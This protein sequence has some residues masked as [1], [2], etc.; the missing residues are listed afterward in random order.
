MSVIS[1][2]YPARVSRRRVALVLAFALLLGILGSL[3]TQSARAATCPCTIFGSQTPGTLAEADTVPVELGVKFRADQDGFITGIRFYKGPGNTGTHTGSLWNAAGTR[4]ATVTFTGESTSGWQQANFATPVTVT[5]NTT[6][7]A[8]YYA[9]VGRYSADVGYFASGSTVNSP[10][11][12]LQDGGDGGNGVYRYGTGGGFPNSTFQSTNYWVDVVFNPSGT[13][14]TKPTVTDRLPASGSTGVPVGTSVSATFGESVQQTSI[15]FTLTGASA[16][17][18]TLNYNSTTRTATLTPNAPLATSTT[19]T[20]SLSGAQDQSGNVMDTITWTFTTAATTSGCPCTLWPNT[21]TPATAATADNSAVEVGVKFRAG[22]DGF[23]TGI[24]FYKG[25][26]NTGTHVGSLWTR[27]GTKLASVTFTGETATGWQQATFASPVPV[28][29]GTTYVASYF[30]PVGRYAN[31]SGYF[32]NTAT[33][34]GPLTAL[35]NG[36]DGLNGLYKYGASGFPTNGFQSTNY[37]VDVV[38]DTSAT[39]TTAPSVV[40]MAPADAATGVAVS[41]PVTATFSEDVSA[42]TM[43]LTGPNGAVVPAAFSYDTQSLTAT[44]TPNAALAASTSYTVSVS[45]AKDAAG[46]TMTPATWSFATGAPPPPGIAQGPGGPIAVVTSSGNPYSK[47][48]AEILRTEGLNEFATIDVSTLSASKLASYDVVVLGA[49]TV[50]SDQAATLSTWVNGGGNLIAMKPS[51]TLSGLLG[52]TPAGG[53]VDDGYLKVDTT[54]APGSGIVSDTIQFHGS[55]D[56]YTLSGAQSIATLYS[57]ATT[58]TSN[59][60]VTLQGVGS[61]GGEAA[62][63]T[64][65]LPRSIVAMRQ[66][67]QAWAGQERDRQSPIRSDDMFFGGSSPDW[68]NLSKVAIPQADEQQR[69]LTNLIEVMNREKKPLPRFWYFPRGLKAVIVGTGDDHGNGGTPGRFDQLLANS[70]ANCSVID[71][72]CYRYSSYVYPNTPRL[73]NSA[74]VSYTN[75]GFE[76]GV[77]ETTNC[78]DFTPT[79]LANNYANDLSAWRSNYPGLPSP[80][81]NRTHC[82]AWSDWASQPK[83]ELANGMRMDGNYYYWPGS[84]IQD[85]PGFMSGSGMPMRF[86]DTDGSMIDVYQA[87]TQMTDESDQ[88]YP[89]TVDQLLDNATGPLGY[90]GAFTANMHTDA[91][92]EPQSDALISSARSHNVP[93]VSGKQMVTWLDGRNA[94]A[95]GNITWSGNTLSFTV[96]GGTGSNE[97][98][99]MLPTAGPGGSVLSAVSRAGSGVDYTTSTVKG[100]EYASFRAADG[101]YTATYSAPAAGAMAF[102]ALSVDNGAATAE[103]S[104]TA[105]WTT[106]RVATSEVAIGTSPSALNTKVKIGDATRKHRLETRRLKPGTKYYYRV[107][108]TDLK[109]QSGT[110]P[111]A[112]KAPATFTT[113]TRDTRAPK[114][115]SARV[116]PLPGGTATVRWTTDEPSTAVVQVGTSKGNLEPVAR[117][118]ELATDHALVLTGLD[119]GRTYLINGLST[120]AAGNQGQSG[121]LKFVTPAWGVS[122]QSAPSFRRG[123][124]GGD[125]N[126]DDQDTLGRVTLAGDSSTARSGTFVSGL[127]DTQAMV[128]WD[129]AVWDGTIPKGATAALLVRTGS[130]SSPDATWTDWTR[131]PADGR[132]DGASRYLQYRVQFTAGAGAKAPSLW[133]VGFSHNADAPPEDAEGP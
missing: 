102:S 92:T 53:S 54:T 76:V 71:W 58:A 3:S 85:R 99:G 8:S 89:F 39:D 95:F 115:T 44:L 17:P 111:A 29:A 20:A 68:V 26:G 105:S 16:V 72:T 60:A 12:A 100:L 131:V 83:T 33:S 127:L 34:R 93:I 94:S 23:V 91:P 125:A 74:A 123:S 80:V 10:L 107:T 79:S 87:V 22:Q 82:I 109:G 132:I 7:V 114:V 90:Y 63:F 124:L 120:D 69:L 48:L 104:A 128:V 84:W 67:N 51:S 117:A 56:R 42:A 118:D 112:D 15:N 40:S 59:P 126:V 50:D 129:R 97:L 41:T 21:T 64:Y 11:T 108:S 9:P 1:G 2:G 47:Y 57:N 121:T 14:T 78:G 24:R 37:W 106:S 116:T 5:A 55:A 110:Y 46:N 130:T 43:T 32:A 4:L 65:D 119:P 103:Q 6:Y 81:S 13:D 62:A 30:A 61:N 49:V 98:T 122:E 36:T 113:P 101:S 88:T 52:L 70:P 19:Y 28:T 38:F 66:G 25:S 133:A 96:T 31:N 86:V 45:G 27:T 35:R 73:T 18:A 75:Q 77:H